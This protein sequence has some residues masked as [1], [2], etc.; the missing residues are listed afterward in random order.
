MASIEKISSVDGGTFKVIPNFEEQ[1][2]ILATSG[3]YSPHNIDLNIYNSSKPNLLDNWYFGNPVNQRGTDG[4]ATTNDQI[5][6][7]RWILLQGNTESFHTSNV[8][9]NSS[10]GYLRVVRNGYTEWLYQPMPLSKCPWKGKEVT[11]SLLTFE[12]ELL[13]TTF[14]WNNSGYHTMKANFLQI[15]DN[16]GVRIVCNASMNILAVKLELGK[17]QSLALPTSD[18]KWILNEIPDFGKQLRRCQRYYWKPTQPDFFL[19]VANKH[20]GAMRAIIPFPVTM[21]SAPSVRY[22]SA[23]TMAI[24]VSKSDCY[25]EIY[26]STNT[27]SNLEFIVP[28][29][30]E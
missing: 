8:Q 9:C 17:R 2:I 20:N 21:E 14:T 15:E 29:F 7:D 28:V 30:G 23:G 22:R 13:K 12:G 19:T 18:G 11:F 16:E 25:A 3:T 10:I 4:K 1:N 6:V 24:T 27:I 5:I 26:N